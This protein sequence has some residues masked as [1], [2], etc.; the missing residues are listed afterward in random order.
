ML[1]V[2]LPLHLLSSSLQWSWGSALWSRRVLLLGGH[3][4]VKYCILD[5]TNSVFWPQC[6]RTQHRMYPQKLARSEVETIL[7][8]TCMP[9]V[10]QFF[11]RTR[12]QPESTGLLMAHQLYLQSGDDSDQ[13][14]VILIAKPSWLC[15]RILRC[16]RPA[17]CTP[18]DPLTKPCSNSGFFAT[19]L[20][21]LDTSSLWA[22]FVFPSPLPSFS[23]SEY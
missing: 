17:L 15:D 3:F 2:N 11:F 23:T 7:Q 19:S 10:T 22:P 21:W 8:K 6:L 20:P 16:E 12:S 4:Q 13:H 14:S 1:D 18:A 9:F 5:G